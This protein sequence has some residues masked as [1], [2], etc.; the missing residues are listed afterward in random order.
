MHD[1][2]A[3]KILSPTEMETLQRDGHFHGSAADR[4]DGFI[5]LSTAAQVE[6]TLRRHFAGVTALCIAAVDVAG[7]G[8]KVRWEASSGGQLYPH[9]Y[10]PLPLAAVIASGPLTRTADGAPNLPT[11]A[12]S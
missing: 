6:G 5:H 1:A 9:L 11:N 4:A 3:Y 2:I 12:G 8:D 10:A 7:L